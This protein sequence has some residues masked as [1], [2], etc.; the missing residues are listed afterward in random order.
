MQARRTEME[1]SLITKHKIKRFISIGKIISYIVFGLWT[2]ITIVPLVWMF[3]SS[4]KSNEELTL[5][6][7]SL[8][9]G[10]FDTYNDDYI[11]INPEL[12]VTLDYDPDVD[13]R[14][15]LIIESTKIAPTRRLMYF[16][17]LKD[18][19]PP[20]LA[21]LKAGEHLKVNQLPLKQQLR[22][23]WDT[24]WFNY[25]SSF[26]R[27]KLALG[28]MNS[29]IYACSA[30]FFIVMLGLM[31]GFGLSKLKFPRLSMFVGGLIGLGYLLTI[32]SVI[33]PLFLILRAVHLT[34]THF[35][36]I[37]VYVAFGLPMSV[38]LSTQFINGLPNSLVESAYMDGATTFRT[39]RSIIV[40][41]CT[42]V[43][44]T[45]A[46]LNALGIWNEFLLVLVLASSEFTK[47]LPVG[48]Y[49]FSSLQSTQFGWQLAAMV[50]ALL[51]AMI[52]YFI[53][54]KRIAKGVVA[55]AIKG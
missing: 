12:N 20:V 16:I 52:V 50:I 45:V 7:Y 23:R 51:P 5:D 28:F 21:N 14:E 33:I 48:V 19:L 37:L 30:T 44:I 26:T 42:P 18:E 32:N 29:V 6:I 49:S 54:N 15:R 22:V 4:F 36:I 27:G 24:I 17:F 8:P 39:F 43:A 11:I 40:P 9:H 55:G 31:T 10:L 13:K 41:M 25:T 35:G 46:I 38:L 2:F 53:F 1:H 47:S 34:D 3:Y